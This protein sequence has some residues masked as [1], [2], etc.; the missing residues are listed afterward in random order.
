MVWKYSHNQH[1]TP[2]HKTVTR[3][4]NFMPLSNL[5]LIQL[6]PCFKRFYT[7]LKLA[8]YTVIPLFLTFLCYSQTCNL[9]SKAPV[10]IVFLCYSQI[11]TLYSNPHVSNV[12]CNVKLA[13]FLF[14][15]SLVSH[16]IYNYFMY[17]NI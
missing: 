4:S 1:F 13:I 10:L 17:W 16:F 7:T 5:Q 6:Y 14:S 3:F 2:S 8:A 9:N 12:R 15:N 11:C